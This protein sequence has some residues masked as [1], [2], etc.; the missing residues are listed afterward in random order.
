MNQESMIRRFWRSYLDTLPEDSH[1]P[2]LPEAWSFGDTPALADELAELVL[3]GTKTAT[4]S[5]L[6]EYEADGESLPAEGALSIVLDGRGE[7]RCVLETVE[8]RIRP[9][10]QVDADFAFQEGEGDRSLSYWREAHHRFF[11]RTLPRIGRAF[12]EDMPLVCERFRVVHVGS[13]VA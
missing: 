3:S 4:S 5:A 12:R 2:P 8:V 10:Q 13:R 11:G 6:W 7:P 9:F 1:R